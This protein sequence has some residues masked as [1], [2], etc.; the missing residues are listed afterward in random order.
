M[1]QPRQVGEDRVSGDVA[2]ERDWQDSAIDLVFECGLVQ[3][4]RQLDRLWIRVRDLD[5]NV[6]LTGDRRLDA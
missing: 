1:R 2:A 6:G 4:R 5:P 3:Q